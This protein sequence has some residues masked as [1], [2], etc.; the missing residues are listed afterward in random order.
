MGSTTDNIK[1]MANK[2]A[3]KLKQG[4]GKAVGSEK[5][6]AKGKVQEIKG[7]GQQAIGKTKSAVKDT[8]NKVTDEINKKL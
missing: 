1:G 8:A 5:M 7:Q 6:Q 3:G 4:V 2:A